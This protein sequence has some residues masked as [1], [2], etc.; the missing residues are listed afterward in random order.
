[1]AKNELKPIKVA[2]MIMIVL[3]FAEANY[4]SP[5]MKIE[6]N[7]ATDKLSCPAQCGI[8]CFLANIG[9]PICYAICVSK[10]PKNPPS[11]LYNCITRC[12]INKPSDINIDARG[13]AATA[14]NSCL[15]ECIKK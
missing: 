12:G 10:C 7:S 11:S 3:G 4:N 14:V 2:V 9:Y 8:D 15:Q 6:P 13:L 1:M 5:S